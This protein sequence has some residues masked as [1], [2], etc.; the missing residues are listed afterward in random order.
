MTLTPRGLALF[1]LLIILLIVF[2]L[3]GEPTLPN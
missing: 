3:P 1:T 2:V